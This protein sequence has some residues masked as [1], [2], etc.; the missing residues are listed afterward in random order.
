M[1]NPFYLLILGLLI[2]CAEARGGGESVAVV[3][4]FT[5]GNWIAGLN[6]PLRISGADIKASTPIAVEFVSGT[7]PSD[8]CKVMRDKFIPQ[9]ILL[10]CLKDGTI[11]LKL[12]ILTLDEVGQKKV[13][14]VNYGPLIINRLDGL[15]IQD[16]GGGGT[17]PSVFG[18]QLYKAHCI[19]CHPEKAEK[20][21]RNSDQIWNAIRVQPRMN[22]ASLLELTRTQ[23][24]QIASYLAV[25]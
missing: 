25:P 14:V 23:L 7:I 4:I 16:P 2:L 21:G 9:N 15:K 6:I 12:Q 10:R 22:N 5:T 11:S 17:D 8:Q 18:E 3:P 19:G 24:E 1:K 20:A 13:L